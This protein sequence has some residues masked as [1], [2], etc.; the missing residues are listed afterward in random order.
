MGC[1]LNTSGGRN[2]GEALDDAYAL[3]HDAHLRA[4]AT[5]G[6]DHPLT[7]SCM[8]AN[9]ADLRSLRRREEAREVEAEAL[10]RLTRSLG[11]QH[12]HTLAARQR[13]RPHWDYEPYLG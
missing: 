5:L 12:H 7:L 2:L 13:T 1:A 9:A 4:R 6:E 8:I 3:S 10:E 11:A